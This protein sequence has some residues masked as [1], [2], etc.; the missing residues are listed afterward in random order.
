MIKNSSRQWKTVLYRVINKSFIEYLI[1]PR[2]FKQ[3]RSL[4]SQKPWDKGLNEVPVNILKQMLAS[5]LPSITQC[6]WLLPALL[7]PQLSISFSLAW[8]LLPLMQ[9]DPFITQP[10][11]LLVQAAFLCQWCFSFFPS[12][13]FSVAQSFWPCSLWTLPDVS[14][15]ASACILTFNYIKILHP[16]WT[17]MSF[18]FS[19]VIQSVCW[20]I[21]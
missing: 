3:E 6:L 17:L 1:S 8:L 14:A 9:C 13:S 15:S 16:L 19:C 5:S 12:F 18:H 11:W 20:R 7:T 2:F 10:F 21:R 4:R